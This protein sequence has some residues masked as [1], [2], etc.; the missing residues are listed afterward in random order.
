MIVYNANIRR[1][2]RLR[3]GMKGKDVIISRVYQLLKG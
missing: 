2:D 1:R 3:G